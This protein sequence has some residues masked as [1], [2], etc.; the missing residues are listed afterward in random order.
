EESIPFHFL[1][2]ELLEFVDDVLDGLDSRKEVEYIRTIIKN[3]TSADRQIKTYYDAGGDENRQEALKAV[4]D[5]L[6]AETKEGI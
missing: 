3:G 4:V 5:Q 6:I 1:A 2:E